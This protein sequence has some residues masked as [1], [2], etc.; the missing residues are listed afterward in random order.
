MKPAE[1]EENTLR[2]LQC[3]AFTQ[4][5]CFNNPLYVDKFKK[6]SYIFQKKPRHV[7]KAPPPTFKGPHFFYQ[8][9]D[10]ADCDVTVS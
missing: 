9:D 3:V 10:F 2:S 1:I 5:P 7:A 6:S 8:H 4:P